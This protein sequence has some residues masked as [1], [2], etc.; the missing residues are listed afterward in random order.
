MSQ[1][2]LAR[3]FLP[4]GPAFLLVKVLPFFLLQSTL[5]CSLLK[6]YSKFWDVQIPNWVY[7]TAVVVIHPLCLVVKRALSSRARQRD[8]ILKGAEELPAVDLPSGEILRQCLHTFLVGYPGEVF[9]KW[10]QIYGSAFSFNTYG[11]K[12]VRCLPSIA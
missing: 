9:W 12:R 6:G 7:T 10:S 11:E 1:F 2:N 5:V 4:P 3:R 8:R